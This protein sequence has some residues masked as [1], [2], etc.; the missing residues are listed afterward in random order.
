MGPHLRHQ[1]VIRVEDSRAAP[2]NGLDDDALD[3]RQLAQRIDLFEAEVVA[4]DV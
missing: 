2:G 1:L 3:G 4:G